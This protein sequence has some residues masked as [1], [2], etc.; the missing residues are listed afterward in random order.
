MKLG[1]MQPYFFPY[2]GYWQLL[3]AVDIFIIYDNL[4]YSKKGW[5]NRNRM[6]LN[7]KDV[8]FT[9][10]LKGDSDYLNIDQRKI[11][12]SFD[13]DKM[14]NRFAAAYRKAP[15]F[16]QT[17]PLVERLVQWNKENLFWFLYHSVV[18]IVEHLAI[19][20]EIRISSQV[21][22]DHTLKSQDK[23]L[24]MCKATGADTY[25]NAIG[26]LAMGLY[27]R[28]KFQEKEVELKFIKTNPIE[29]KQFGNEF[30]PWLSIIDVMM[31][32]PLERTREYLD[33]YELV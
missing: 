30:V 24:A 31:F 32:N 33:K 20:V 17:F 21:P 13:K 6:L 8:L 29:Y 1:I 12:E 7:G 4:E 14:L 22:I 26:A 15:Y 5:I 10:P 16:D 11:A 18:S 3:T 2:I 27:S 23:V 19:Q 28:K 9:L 25:I